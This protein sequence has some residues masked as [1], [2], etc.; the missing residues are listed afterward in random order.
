MVTFSNK[1]LN[2]W[3]ELAD[4][5]LKKNTSNGEQ[6]LSWDSEE[7]IKIKT[8]Y[9]KEDLEG[10]EHLN[11]MPGFPP[12]VR[13][14][15]ATMY[16]G[17]PWTIRQYAGFSTAKE[18]NA[19]YK[20]A[21]KS[22]QKGLSIAF[23]LATHRGYDSDHPRVIGDVGKAGVA[24]DT[25]E[26]M[27]VL[28]NEIP[29]EKMSVSMTMNG[30]VLPILASYI[31]AAEEQGV[32]MEK[33]SG[34]IQNDILKEFLVRNTYIYP[35]KASMRIISDI[36]EFTSK[37]MPKFNSI[38]ISGYHM[39]EAGA[40]QVQE[41][42][43]TIADGLEYVKA[44][45]NNG[46]KVDDFAPRLSFFFAI[47]MN[48][49]MEVSK[50]R[51]ARFLWAKKMKKI[52]NPHS[53]NSLMLRTHC[54]TS[55]VSLTEK[56]A[57]NNIVR[58]TIEAMAAV[59]GGTQSLHTN[60]FDE[61][62]ALPTEMSSRIARNT[63]LILQ[64]ETNITKT[65]DPLAGSYYV[66]SLTNSLIKHAEVLIDE[67]LELG[68]MTKAIEKGYPNKL[69][70]ESA[71]RKQ[72]KIDSEEQIIVGV[73][74]FVNENEKDF[75]ILEI[76]NTQVRKQQINSISKI[77]IN[78]NNEKC[79]MALKSLT[80]AAKEKKGNLLE[81]SIT[82]ARERATIGE[83][84]FALEKVFDRYQENL[85]IT[86][87]EYTK[88]FGDNVKIDD[89]KESI[90]KFIQE[91]GRKP[92]M[93]VAKLGQDGH[94]RGAKVIASSFSDL[95]FDIEITKLFLT[96][97]ELIE[98]ADKISPDIVGISS[99]AAAHMTLVNQFMQLSKVNKKKFLVI[100][101][102]VI[103]KKDIDKLREMG[104]SE[105][106][107]PGTNIINACY[108]ILNLIKYGNKSNI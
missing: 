14:P 66:E 41:L 25:V 47:G 5:E 28:F 101:G 61:A 65:V 89:I 95:G 102:G 53:L 74:K 105:V 59:M 17:R 50:L 97:K 93:L 12:F 83:I 36:I 24:I 81:L 34:T 58:T 7:G 90:N 35:P 30:A 77:K 16:S 62:V 19:F 100:C 108:K 49:F 76:D 10:L 39:Q 60:S 21:L 40:N 4:K 18:S 8:L 67:I 3:N 52:F 79:N 88:S 45:I 70:E 103:P 32:A 29:L 87:G 37:K 64:N 80:E 48:F 11:T 73:N 44:A 15:K 82:A 85:N 72:A 86:K 42:A 75:E 106:F 71:I 104:V 68:G 63:Q 26:D 31:V 20:K 107:G 46:L 43:F 23:D 56:D 38:S 78:R 99:H 94:D 13:G 84:S 55:G 92:K 96:P 54:Q 51:A 33:L 1:D 27:K 98:E 57:Y 69:I 9:T 91:Q 22:G 6:K 2:D